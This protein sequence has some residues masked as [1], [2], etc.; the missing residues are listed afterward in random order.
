MGATISLEC[1]RY[2]D[3]DYFKETAWATNVFQA[4]GG[5]V[6]HPG[7]DNVQDS[8]DAMIAMLAPFYDGT[9]LWTLDETDQQFTFWEMIVRTLPENLI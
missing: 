1:T 9:S 8:L 6:D 7:A 4:E 5:W 3:G 2:F